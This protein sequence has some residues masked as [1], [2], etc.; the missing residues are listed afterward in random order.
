MNGA[1]RP[2]KSVKSLEN[3]IIR[4]FQTGSSPLQIGSRSGRDFEMHWG[5]RMRFTRRLRK[6]LVGVHQ[7]HRAGRPY[8]QPEAMMRSYRSEY[9]P[10]P[11][12]KHGDG[13]ARLIGGQALSNLK[14]QYQVCGVSRCMLGTQ[15]R[16]PMNVNSDPT[17]R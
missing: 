13:P 3:T 4:F 5:P 14:L 15:L 11:R 7:N 6:Y 16:I 9:L 10:H 8:A 1:K 17:K 12:S 2:L